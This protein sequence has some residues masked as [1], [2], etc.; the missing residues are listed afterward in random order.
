MGQLLLVLIYFINSRSTVKRISCNGI[1]QDFDLRQNGLMLL[2]IF[3]I[4]S[5]LYIF[6]ILERPP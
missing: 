6:V 3:A 4:I 2:G 1:E 5:Y